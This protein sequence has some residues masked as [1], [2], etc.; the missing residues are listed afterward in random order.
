MA[1]KL[2]LSFK[3]LKWPIDSDFIQPLS[4]HTQKT[5]ELSSTCSR[6]P[7]SWTGTLQVCV[8][9]LG[10]VSLFRLLSSVF[11]FYTLSPVSRFLSLVHLNPSPGV[12]FLL[13]VVWQRQLFCPPHPPKLLF[14]LLKPMSPA[15]GSSSRQTLFPCTCICT[16]IRLAP[17]SSASTDLSHG[18]S[19]LWRFLICILMNREP[20]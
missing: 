14:L 20:P 19:P 16:Q 9:A 4:A 18:A 2:K 5:A 8:R 12:R 13:G 7:Q 11:V 3:G 10:S 17:S 6:K 1:Y 15:C